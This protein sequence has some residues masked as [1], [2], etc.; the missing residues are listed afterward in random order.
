MKM[1]PHGGLCILLLLLLVVMELSQAHRN[2]RDRD[3]KKERMHEAQDRR[4]RQRDEKRKERPGLLDGRHHWNND[5][6]MR[7]LFGRHGDRWGGRHSFNFGGPDSPFNFGFSWDLG[8]PSEPWWKGPNVCFSESSDNS[9]ADGD[10][11]HHIST[12]T[13][14]CEESE[15]SYRCT[16]SIT[17]DGLKVTKIEVHECCHGYARDV[18]DFGCPEKVTLTTLPELARTLGLNDFLRAVDSVGLREELAR[19][20]V[21][22]FAPADGSF[23]PNSGVLSASSGF[24]LQQ[25]EPLMVSR[26][27]QSKLESEL[28]AM[29]LG[30]LLAGPRRVSSFRD[31]EILETGS[32]YGST[33][34]IN[35][36]SRPEKLTTANCVRVTSADNLA[37]NGVLH[38]V[39]KVLPTVTSP[40]MDLIQRDQQFSFLKTAVAR[41][42]LVSTLQ[43]AGQLTLLAPTNSAFQK[44]NR[45][46]YDRLLSGNPECLTKVLKHHLLPNV[47]CSGVILQ[48][49][50]STPNLLGN[51]LN[52]TRTEDGKLF[53]NDVQVVRADVMATNGVLHIIDE[54][55][56]PDDALDMVTTAKSNGL[57][58]FV[59][60]LDM[61]GL[62]SRL[63][64]EDNITV[65]APT[66]EAIKALSPE[67][68]KQLSSDQ[69]FLQSVLSYHV[70]P[71]EI[72]CSGLTNNLV[73]D[74]LNSK[75]KLRISDYSTFPFGSRQVQTVQC[76]QVVTRNMASCNAIVHVI[77]RVLLPPR[78]NVLDVL[79]GD[80]NYST[81]LRLVKM[82]GIAD[83]LQAEGPLTIFAPTN[84]AFK[85]LGNRTMHEL[86]SDPKQ[87]ASILNLHVISGNLCCAG[88]T[89]N[90]WWF[91]QRVR[92][93]DGDTL[94][95]TRNRYDI[96]EVSGSTISSCDNVATNGV[97]H[98]IDKVL[99]PEPDPWYM[100]R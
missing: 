47:I 23:A 3:K 5:R 100:F 54:V 80:T 8:A 69:G 11:W 90:P 73:L 79:S 86:T 68:L 40:L 65:F 55:L 31:E 46:L 29:L 25:D 94:F 87:L 21:T 4:G 52:L 1:R 13:Q 84:Q 85:A 82:A 71:E 76:A 15:A 32:P 2:R 67:L 81:L 7:R 66:N 62:T 36:F 59:N 33:I 50:A 74:T 43:Q 38:V 61:A 6:W 96:P 89:H 37:T 64:S 92:T 98:G 18:N 35:F 56:I 45:G 30:H 93:V 97:V 49:S 60:L 22:V 41:A 72:T 20:N 53:V 34:R 77:D 17:K 63:Q 26:P 42:G 58:E 27:L 70:V 99:V 91:H 44:L 75:N 78:G 88:I 51:A 24:V 39:E 95:L 12:A 19:G 57:T 14:A 83:S 16:T 10:V 28:Q 48:G 9:T